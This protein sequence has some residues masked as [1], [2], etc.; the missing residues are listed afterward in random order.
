MNFTTGKIDGVLCNLL[1]VHTD[2]RGW[3][4]ELFRQDELAAELHPAMAYI[5]ETGPGVTRGPH[6]HVQQTDCFRFLGAFRVDLW[7]NRPSSPTF[8]VHETITSGSREWLQ[9]VIPPGVVHAYKNVGTAPALTINLPNRLYKG[10]G[11]V[12]PVDEIRHEDD[13]RSP[14]QVP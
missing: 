12:E 9:I 1:S 10:A 11:R 8:G 5:S 4:C 14:F 7:D 2:A 6:E 13:P 3:L